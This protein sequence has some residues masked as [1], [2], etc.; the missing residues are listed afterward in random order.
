[1]KKITLYCILIIACFG[2]PNPKILQTQTIQDQSQDN[3]MG[4]F[5]GVGF[6]AGVQTW[7][8]RYIGQ[9]TGSNLFLLYDTSAKI[10]A[11]HNLSDNIG[12]RYYYSLDLSYMQGDVANNVFNDQGSNKQIKP[13]GFFIISQTH[14]FNTDL[15]F[16]AYSKENKRLDLIVGV[17]VGAFVPEYHTREGARRSINENYASSY[18]VDLQAR[19]NAGAKMVFDKRYGLE[20]MAKIPI[21][22]PATLGTSYWS[23]GGATIKP[24]ASEIELANYA[25]NLSFIIEL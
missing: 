13:V 21:V 16:N 9:K 8:I 12:L 10:G 4:F 5:F 2:A 3:Q 6:G 11:Y 15:I 17:G 19:I 25:I 1:M 22:S 14:M 18:T 7:K 23:A 20:L 24:E